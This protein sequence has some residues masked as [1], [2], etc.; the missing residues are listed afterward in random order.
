MP[1][2]QKEFLGW[3]TSLEANKGTVEEW[4]A[5]HG[6][7]TRSTRRWK[8]DPRFRKAW[9]AVADDEMLGPEFLQPII[10]NLWRRA[11][12]PNARDAVKAA[13]TLFKINEAVRPPVKR[14]EITQ[15]EEFEQLSDAELAAFLET[16]AG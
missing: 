13:E 8:Q 4:A 14:I 16:Q 9:E 7:S 10:Q 15:G 5:E 3:L 2:I 12:D 11:T 6:V 1:E